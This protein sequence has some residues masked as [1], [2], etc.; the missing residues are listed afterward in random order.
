MGEYMYIEIDNMKYKVVVIRKNNKNTYIRVKDDLIIYVTT[1]IFTK[2]KYIQKLLIENKNA[3]GKMINKAKRKNELK[4]ENMILG[5][6]TNKSLQEKE[7]K[8]YANIIFKERLDLI[9]KKIEEDIPYPT[10]K[11]RKMTS[12]WGVCNKKNLSITIN[13]ELIKRDIKYLDYVIL[14]ELCHFVCFNHSKEFWNLVLKY[15]KNYKK[16]RKEMKEW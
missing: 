6:K 4:L 2:D 8:K 3:I 12:R 15:N 5:E 16:I 7:L 10:L 1:N 9:Y 14:H 13:L 11:L